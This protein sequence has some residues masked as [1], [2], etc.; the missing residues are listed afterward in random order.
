MLFAVHDYLFGDCISDYTVPFPLH[1][2]VNYNLALAQ[3]K[4]SP[5]QEALDALAAALT[6]EPSYVPAR[7]LAG[8]ILVRAGFPVDAAE[9]WR[10]ALLYE[11]E[12]V[13]LRNN[14]GNVLMML[15][16]PD[17]AREQWEESVRLDPANT[18]AHHNLGSWHSQRGD[19]DEALRHFERMPGAEAGHE[20]CGR[21]DRLPA[22]AGR[23]APNAVA[24]RRPY[25]ERGQQP[26]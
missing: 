23:R 1:P 17:E 4:R 22:Q 25:P 16:K 20:G 21:G 6:G 12:R 5:P 2:G 8:S 11:P 19:R 3:L 14:L 26:F 24:D 18:T 7:E 9:Q 15:E 13:T 10:V